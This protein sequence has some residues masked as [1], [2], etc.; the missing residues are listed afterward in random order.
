MF[1]NLK[2]SVAYRRIYNTLSELCKMPMRIFYP[3]VNLNE[4]ILPKYKDRR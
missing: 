1:L 4:G 2:H 3:N